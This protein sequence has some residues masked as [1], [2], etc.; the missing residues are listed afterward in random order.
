MRKDMPEASRSV[1]GFTRVLANRSM[2]YWL[3]PALLLLPGGLILGW[4]I[5]N[6]S[7]DRISFT[8][9]IHA[10]F[11]WQRL[12]IE[13]TIVSCACAVV[14]EHFQV[15][16]KKALAVLI[17]IVHTVVASFLIIGRSL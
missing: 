13:S 9:A 5:F 2:L 3:I 15:K 11:A 6:N 4:D 16:Y 17:V 14:V 1:V 12:S 7:T 10:L 8:E